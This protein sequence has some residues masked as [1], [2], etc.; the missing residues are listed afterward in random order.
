M[1][2]INKDFNE[3]NDDELDNVSGGLGKPAASNLLMKG[4][5]AVV[6]DLVK[7][8]NEK[9]TAS[10]LLLKSDNTKSKT[11]APTG[12]IIKDMPTGRC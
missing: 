5:S 12:G 7:R 1:T 10:N 2:D 6:S 3:L 8:G 4:S 9:E 11:P